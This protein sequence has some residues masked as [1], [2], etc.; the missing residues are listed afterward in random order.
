M[1]TDAS[2]VSPTLWVA[3][4][5]IWAL[6]GCAS[7]WADRQSVSDV[8]SLSE[9]RE[10]LQLK[11]EPCVDRT[12]NKDQD[13]G[14]AATEALVT[15]LNAKNE[16]E[17]TSQGR[18][19]LTCDVTAFA[20][21][22]SFKRWLVPGT[23]ATVGQ[24]AVMVIDSKTGE[25]VAIVR[26]RSTVSAGGFYTVDADEIILDSALDDVVE[27]LRQLTPGSRPLK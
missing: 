24:V 2:G 12:G 21:G 9:P 17:V 26:G 15:K 3:Q 23:G 1:Q 5:A 27:Q 6:A 7:D 4:I 19:V 16:F 14:R 11:L 25:S 8:H 13:V 20:K 22:S 18:Y 10:R